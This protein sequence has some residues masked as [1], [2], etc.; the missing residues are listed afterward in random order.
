MTD[1]ITELRD[2]HQELEAFL[3]S[4]NAQAV[5]APLDALEESANQVGKAWGGSW[6]GYQSNVYY[7]DLR[8]APP[9]AHFSS[10]WAFLG[11]FQGT[12]GDWQEYDRDTVKHEVVSRARSPDLEPGKAAANIGRELFEQKRD[13]LLSILEAAKPSGVDKFIEQLLEEAGKLRLLNA[14]QYIAVWQP[15]GKQ[16]SRDTIAITQGLWTPPH[17]EV[18]AEVAEARNPKKVC[19]SLTK[20]T[21]K[22]ASHLERLQRREVRSERIRT[23]VFIGHG[24]S[25]VWKDLKDFIQDRLRLP[26]DEFNRMPINT[27]VKT[28]SKPR[29]TDPE[30]IREARIHSVPNTLSTGFCQNSASGAE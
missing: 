5:D 1:A 25:T 30:E 10:E 7:A 29:T 8:P 27:M 4:G 6:L 3:A 17:I 18:L 28:G 2:I 16:M 26:W 13:Q 20:V 24:R 23:N 9:G 21:L 14:S 11:A 22:A 15:S 12:T 19:E